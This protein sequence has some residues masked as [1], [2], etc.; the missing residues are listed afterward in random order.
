MA[1]KR[2]EKNIEVITYIEFIFIVS[3]FIFVLIILFHPKE[4]LKKSILNEKSNYRLTVAYLEAFIKNSPSDE[5]LLYD[6]AQRVIKIRNMDLAVKLLAL[7]SNSKDPELRKKSILLAYKIN[8]LIYASADDEKIKRTYKK[9]AIEDLKRIFQDEVYKKDVDKW[10]SE[11]IFFDQ[12]ELELKAL[13]LLY[14]KT[15]ALS[16]LEK[17][18]YLSS[19]IKKYDITLDALEKLEKVDK[20]HR[21][22]W[23]LARYYI[24]MQMKRYKDAEKL[25]LKYKNYHKIAKI[26]PG[27]YIYTKKYSKIFNIYYNKFKRTHRNIYFKKSI[28]ILIQQKKYSNAIEILHK[29]EDYYIHNKPMRQFIIKSYLSINRT[30]LANKY[31]SKILKVIY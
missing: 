26:I 29:Y 1:Y 24:Y 3:F 14:E 2:E 31:A 15:K 17:I 8:K 13:K 18:Y 19:N 7:L 30:D 20:K 10:Y 27:F 4:I 12:K 6:L 22:K 5:Y 9:K 25:L 16:L 21:L 11:A 28:Q 23:V